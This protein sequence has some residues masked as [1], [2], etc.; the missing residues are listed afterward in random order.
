MSNE[1]ANMEMIEPTA[2]MAIEKANVDMQV[3]TAHKYPRSITA[4]KRDM[5]ELATLDEEVAESCVYKRPVGGGKNA[6]GKSVRLAEIAASCFGNFAVQAVIV[7]Q[8][9]RYVVARGTARDFEKNYTVSAEVKEC[10]VKADGEPYSERQA[11]VVAKVAL[12]K[13]RRDATFAVIPAALI[14]PAEKAIKKLLFGGGKSMTERRSRVVAWIDKLPISSKRVY[15]ALGIAGPD[16]INADILE[17]LT[18][19]RTAI[20]DGDT[21]IDEAF[22]E[23]KSVIDDM[24]PADVEE[25]K[26]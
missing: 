23:I 19:L 20:I 17:E 2:L 26:E 8:T 18:G 25:G 22:P 21:T 12:A 24:K 15:S 3:E 11:A 4:F 9:P 10:T 16:D 7:E 6:E 5:V 14:L 1:V 13:A